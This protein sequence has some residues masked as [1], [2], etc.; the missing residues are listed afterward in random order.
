MNTTG[1]KPW[2]P[3]RKKLKIGHFLLLVFLNM[4]TDNF[5]ALLPVLFTLH[6]L[7]IG[8]NVIQDGQG[9]GAVIAMNA[10]LLHLLVHQFGHPP[11]QLPGELQILIKSSMN[12]FGGH[13]LSLRDFPDS[14]Q[15][16]TPFRQPYQQWKPLRLGAS[17]LPLSV[18][19]PLP[20][21]QL[22]CGFDPRRHTQIL[23]Y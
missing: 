7:T 8:L 23:Y 22:C 2:D 11:G 13:A 10:L 21:H 3:K 17:G 9:T 15:L 5:H 20:L 14:L 6:Q 12:C 18:S 19:P 4:A 1:D 16:V